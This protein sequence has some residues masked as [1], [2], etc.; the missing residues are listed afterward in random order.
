MKNALAILAIAAMP[1]A[2]QAIGDA[3]LNAIGTVES[4]NN[5][6]AVGDGTRARG[7]FQFHKA[8]W[9]HTSE[10][11]KAKGK[12]VYGYSYAHDKDVA[13]EYARDYLG[14]FDN[15]LEKRLGR[16]PELWEIYAAYNR[17]LGG[18]AKADYK[19]ENLPP[20]TQR[21]CF[22]LYNLLTLGSIKKR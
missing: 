12:A 5:P 22:R 17:G 21:A 13:R 18:F 19:F 11:R 2:S 1:V 8:A 20:H 15:Q 9:S 7:E 6:K 14:W 10:I 3:E 4:D 16:K